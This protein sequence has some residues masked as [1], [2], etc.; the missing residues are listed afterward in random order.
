MIPT[1]T[2]QLIE[3]KQ[4]AE[5]RHYDFKREVD[6]DKKY[7]GGGKS[8]KER[9]V[10]DVVAFLNGD[11]GHLL[12]G[13]EEAD[14]VWKQ[15]LPMSGDRERLSNRFLQVIQDNIK[16]IPTK[17]DVVPIDVP[18]GFI[19][20]IRIPEHW[21]KP[22]QNALSGAF[23]TR[24]GARNRVLAVGEI[25]E[26]FASIERM[27]ADLAKYFSDYE[28]SLVASENI[29][30]IQNIGPSLFRTRVPEEDSATGP[31]LQIGV[32]P[33]QHYDRARPRYDPAQMARSVI[34]AFHGGHLPRLKGCSGGFEAVTLHER[35]F[36]AADWHI[37]VNIKF[38]INMPHQRPD[39][40]ALNANLASYMRSVG[41]FLD[42]EQVVGPYAVMLG[43][44]NLDEMEGWSRPRMAASVGDSRPRIV[45]RLDDQHMLKDFVEQTRSALYG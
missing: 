24:S 3:T 20:N 6:L 38:P 15:Y 22:Y 41:E 14:G 31:R 36:V 19:L 39:I 7:P 28:R 4:I 27:E 1:P 5:G 35:L 43:I 8:A 2:R 32:L 45:E 44:E 29:E 9:F 23:Y 37:L 21:A 34:S 33:R 10:D 42:D 40:S 17:V 16:P 18:G 13:V 11:A 12:V 26:L 25:Q 30:R